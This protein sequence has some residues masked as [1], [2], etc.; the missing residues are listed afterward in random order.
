[1]NFLQKKLNRQQFFPSLAIG[2][3][4][5]FIS[6]LTPAIPMAVL[7]F[8]DHLSNNYLVIGIK[9]V[10]L[11][12]IIAGFVIGIGS[13][14]KGMLGHIDLSP[15]LAT[16]IADAVD[17]LPQDTTE[18]EIFF[19]IIT[20]LSI[21]SAIKG[22]IYF[23][24]G[25]LRLAEFTNF[26]PQP[27]MAGFITG[28]GLLFIRASIK[29]ATNINLN[30]SELSLFIQPQIFI[31]LLSTVCFGFTLWLV[32]KFSRHFLTIP[33]FILGGMG[34]FYLSLS[35]TNISIS[36]A[37]KEGW[38]LGPFPDNDLV[39]SLDW[40][41]FKKIHWFLVV[42]KI[43]DIIAFML[44]DVFAF[45]ISLGGIEKISK[46]NINVNHELKISGIA[47][48]LNVLF[49]GTVLSASAYTF[50]TQKMELKTR[51]ISFFF[52][53]PSITFLFVNISF[54][55]F[56]PKVIVSGI[57]AYLGISTLL[58]H[59][60]EE[61]FK[62]SKWEYLLMVVIGLSIPTGSLITGV[63]IGLVNSSIIFA[64]QASRITPI[65]EFT[66][67]KIDNNKTGK[68]YILK[69]EGLIFF[70]NMNKLFK[71]LKKCLNE[72]LPEISKCLILDFKRVKFLDSSLTEK[73]AN[74][75]REAKNKNVYLLFTN[76]N[77]K[78]EQ[79]LYRGEILKNNKS[80]NLVFPNIDQALEW[81]QK[82]I[83]EKS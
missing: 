76:L 71:E 50:A 22:I 48:I 2:F 7:L 30:L 9:S 43:P 21:T 67:F 46:Q 10:L 8:G 1:M 16:I 72:N 36:E 29:I 52:T 83:L 60:Y 11:S 70:G 75:Q 73:L 69:L 78:H 82:N 23:T 5:G 79:Q 42:Q 80:L 55:A 65:E 51:L 20:I 17:I 44:I 4:F 47:S 53:V 58:D 59:L 81:F 33:M 54:L 45:A 61:W 18:S 26:F 37:F 28:M 34:L 31:K 15:I 66:A 25:K 56:F 57:F 77:L 41:D 32:L 19:T 63:V 74:F 14:L 35:L 38:L 68:A 24:V 6:I 40:S 49:G 12:S 62:V 13:S 3:S 27:I 64:I 39:Q